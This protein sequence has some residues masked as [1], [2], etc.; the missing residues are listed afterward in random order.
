MKKFTEAFWKMDKWAVDDYEVQATAFN[1]V[2]D[3]RLTGPEKVERMEAM[4]EEIVRDWEILE[5]YVDEEF[6]NE[7]LAKA[8]VNY[9]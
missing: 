2:D 5:M 7:E 4:L 8:L 6:T 1:I 3:E 9:L